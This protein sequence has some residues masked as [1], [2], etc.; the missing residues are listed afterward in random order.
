M[1]SGGAHLT[2]KVEVAERAKESKPLPNV[3]PQNLKGVSM[4]MCWAGVQFRTHLAGPSGPRNTLGRA[5][6]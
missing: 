1:C 3:P 5:S 2:G 4:L 6:C